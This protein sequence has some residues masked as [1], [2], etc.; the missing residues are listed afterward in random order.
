[1][2]IIRFDSQ[3]FG[4]MGDGFVV[5]SLPIQNNPKLVMNQRVVRSDRQ[6]PLKQSYTVAPATDLQYRQRAQN[7]EHNRGGRGDGDATDAPR[8]REIRQAKNDRHE[9]ADGGNV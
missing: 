9:K 7:K 4:E 3:R 6:G 2:K 1:M 8:D 5:F